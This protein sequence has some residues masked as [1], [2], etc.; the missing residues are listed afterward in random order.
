MQATGKSVCALYFAIIAVITLFTGTNIIL[1]A[2]F[3]KGASLRE[4]VL[5]FRWPSGAVEKLS[6]ERAFGISETRTRLWAD[7]RHGDVS[8]NIALENI[9]L[10]IKEGEFIALVGPS[11]SGKS[12]L[13]HLIGGLDTPTKGTIIINTK[14]LS[15]LNDNDL[16]KY[17]NENVGFVFQ[18][19]YLESELSALRNILIPSLFNHHSK[20]D[21]NRATKLL[22]E[23]ELSEK[24]NSPVNE[25]SGGQKQR[26]AIARALMNNPA[27]II[28]D[29]PTGNL[30][31][32]T[33]E[34]I[35]KLLKKLHKE[36]GITILIATHDESIAK[37]ADKIIK[38]EDGQLC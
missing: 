12:T 5:M 21:Q 26:V 25:L 24:I 17:R 38:I 20:D 11:G 29:E 34:K 14:D 3:D 18:E 6:D 28:A 23:V 2:E 35:I 32:K 31:S 7:A 33:G 13:L 9:N 15:L 4:N 16:S 8:M 19:F 10:E 1:A 27:I 36:H 22:K 37:A 30:D